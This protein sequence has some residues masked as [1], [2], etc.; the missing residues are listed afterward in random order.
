[1][2]DVLNA[3]E[4]W[5][6]LAAERQRL[7]S[8]SRQAAGLSSL[9]QLRGLG[10]HCPP[11][12]PFHHVHSESIRECADLVIDYESNVEHPKRRQAPLSFIAPLAAAIPRG[13]VVHVKTDHVAEFASAILPQLRQPIVLVTGDSDMAPV[14]S[15]RGLLDHPMIGH[16][17]AQNCDLGE[18]HPRLSPIPIGLD[19]P[20]Y[21]KFEKRIGFLADALA[22]RAR[23][24]PLFKT[25]D[26]GDQRRFNAAAGGARAAV[27]RKPLA[28]LCTFHK[29]HRIAPDISGLPDRVAAAA[30]LGP[31]PFCHFV[32]RRMPQDKCW[33][34]H[35]DFAFEASPQGK[36]MD[37]FRTWEALALG[38]VPIVRTSPLDLLYRA[39]DLPVAI[40]RDW[41]EVTL[42]RLSQ[43]AE[44]LVPRLE[45]ARQKLAADYWS[46]I[47]RARA[48]ALA[49]Y[50]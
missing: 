15:H 1:M 3:V 22:G 23:F 18:V 43:W 48:A 39:H 38:T 44:E 17:F 5:I 42:Q 11:D 24:D 30:A 7:A 10:C 36:G 47:I 16:W 40:V 12:L 6:G 26:T 19:N 32:Q 28:V 49:A 34:M 9:G 8:R 31:Q 33:R 25:N 45:G 50:G 46:G 20:V 21:T 35:A 14:R 27:G 37:C 4:R 29:N 41:A 13:A 2:Q